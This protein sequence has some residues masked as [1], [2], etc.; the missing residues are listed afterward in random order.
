MMY[1]KNLDDDHHLSNLRNSD[2]TILVT[3]Q[4]AYEAPDRTRDLSNVLHS[5]GIPH[6]LELWGHDVNHDWVWWRKMLPY[7]LGRFCS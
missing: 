6:S 7:Y 2:F 3:G 4:G 5:K 1:M